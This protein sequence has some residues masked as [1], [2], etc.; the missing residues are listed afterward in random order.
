MNN[1][2]K[3]LVILIAVFLCSGMFFISEMVKYSSSSKVATKIESEV[4]ES[5]SEENNPSESKET[6]N[7]SE[8]K[9]TSDNTS[10][11]QDSKSVENKNTTEA[12]EKTEPTKQTTT[13]Q[14]PQQQPQPQPK[15][16]KVIIQNGIT[17]STILSKSINASNKSVGE[18]TT[19]ALDS[20]GVDYKATGFGPTMYIASIAGLSEK[21][22]GPTSGWTYYVQKG[23]SGSFVKPG[24][25]CGSYK[26]QD[27]DVVL[28]KYIKEGA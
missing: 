16:S 12:K 20:K 15:S 1:K 27:G 9:S 4:K 7:N 22:E 19:S 11:Q 8:D 24:V 28:W 17:G 26:L 18:A 25:S 13:T 6:A 21:A 2:K 23:G 10:N 3:I 5:S 14:E